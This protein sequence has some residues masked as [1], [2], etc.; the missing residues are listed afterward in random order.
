[1]G[2]DQ[3]ADR[4]DLQTGKLSHYSLDDNTVRAICQVEQGTAVEVTVAPPF[5]ATWWFRSTAVLLLIAGATTG[6]SHRVRSLEARGRELEQQVAERTEELAAV[7]AIAEEVGATVNPLPPEAWT[8]LLESQVVVLGN[9]IRA[10]S[11][12]IPLAYRWLNTILPTGTPTSREMTGHLICSI[13]N[14]R[15]PSSLNV[16]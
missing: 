14:T 3:G 1:M 15:G 16:S 10:D 5:W 8:E 12:H 13:Q 11:L 2:T 7:N 6:Y 9:G 4:L